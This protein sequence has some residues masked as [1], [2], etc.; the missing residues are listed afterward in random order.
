LRALT[1]WA[2]SA[3]EQGLGFS[4][5]YLRRDARWLSLGAV[6]DG[7]RLV[8]YTLILLLFPEVPRVFALKNADHALNPRLA[9]RLMARIQH[10]LLSE[11]GRPQ[12]LL[13]TQRAEVLDALD[14]Q[15]DR[16]RLFVVGRDKSG[17]TVVR[18]VEH[19]S[20]AVATE[21]GVTLSELWLSGALGGMPNL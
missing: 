2:E 19:Q 11:H 6:D 14:L 21:H 17:A 8:L 3:L 9:R 7:T 15:D 12:V 13:A 16:V 18:R 5:R 1:E 4:D 20:S 10:I